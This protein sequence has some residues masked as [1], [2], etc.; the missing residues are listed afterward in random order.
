MT[1]DQIIALLASRHTGDVFVAECKT[2][3]SQGYTHSRLDAWAALKSWAH[4]CVFGYEVKV[5]RGDFLQDEKWRAYLDVCNQ[6]YFVCP[7]GVIDPT[8]VPRDAGLL[9][10]S[11][12]A[13]MLYTKKKAPHRQMKKP[14]VD[15]LWY[16]LY[17]RAKITREYTGDGENRRSTLSEWVKQKSDGQELSYLVHR[18]IHRI[19]DDVRAENKRLKDENER[20]ADIRTMMSEMGIKPSAWRVRHDVERILRA[21]PGVDD[22]VCALAD[23]H[24]R[25]GTALKQLEALQ[26][27]ATKGVQI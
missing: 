7:P 16:I 23:A 3:K 6:F 1:S 26:Q 11:K 22:L 21:V 18:K 5:G 10:A 13:A 19:V 4:P 25:T 8:E 27:E 15:L 24:G 20:Y 12:N 2:G 9:Y 17:S 14:P